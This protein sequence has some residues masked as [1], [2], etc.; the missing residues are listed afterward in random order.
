MLSIERVRELEWQVKWILVY[1]FIGNMEQDLEQLV[2]EYRE[3]RERELKTCEPP[4]LLP[5]S[6]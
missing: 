6:P 4:S 1:P 2:K 5:P 3:L